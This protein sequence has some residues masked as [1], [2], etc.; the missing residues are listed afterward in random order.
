[1]VREPKSARGDC[2]QQTITKVQ[3]LVV[4]RNRRLDNSPTL[5][6]DTLRN[7]GQSH[8]STHPY[9]FQMKHTYNTSGPSLR[10]RDYAYTLKGRKR[11]STS[12]V[13]YRR[14]I[15]LSGNSINRSLHGVG[16]INVN[17]PKQPNYSC[18]L[19]KIKFI[20]F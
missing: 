20:T 18:S 6:G 2:L 4:F 9:P 14:L 7:T 8:R 12:Y 5:Q 3:R 19:G 10:L 13:S 1:M 11:A 16:P 17:T 15:L